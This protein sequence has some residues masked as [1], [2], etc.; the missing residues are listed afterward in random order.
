MGRPEEPR[1]VDRAHDWVLSVDATS[2]SRPTCNA[3]SAACRGRSAVRGYRMPRCGFYLGSW[4]RSTDWYPNPQLRLATAARDGHAAGAR[5]GVGGRTVGSLR[6]DLQHYPS[7]TWPTT[8]ADRYVTTL[9]A[10]QL[11]E[12]G[13]NASAVDL[14]L[15]PAAAFLR[16]YV[17]KR[18]VRQGRVGLTVSIMNSYYV[19]LK[20]AKLF[21]LQR[22][23]QVGTRQSAVGSRQ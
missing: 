11:A 12:D 5:D 17:L 8:R 4:I 1:R 23:R 7:R 9:A 16:N 13:R 20:F 10:R 14:L 6:S 2:G 22:S 15:H 21:E 18:G 3:K 19:F